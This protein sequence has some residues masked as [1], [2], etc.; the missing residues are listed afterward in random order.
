MGSWGPGPSTRPAPRWQKRL[1]TAQPGVVLP[2]IQVA[3]VW[4]VTRLEQRLPAR[5]DDATIQRICEQLFDNWLDQQAP[6]LLCG[7]QNKPSDEPGTIQ[8]A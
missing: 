3:D 6:E 5:L 2:P 8:P 1:R 4:L 7:A